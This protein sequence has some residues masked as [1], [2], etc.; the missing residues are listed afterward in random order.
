[1]PKLGVAAP[2]IAVAGS[3][4]NLAA[5]VLLLVAGIFTLRQSRRA[6]TLHWIYAWVKIPA[7]IV[8]AIAMAWMWHQLF[9]ASGAFARP[10]WVTLFPVIPALV[11]LIYPSAL[12]IVLRSRAVRAYYSGESD[13]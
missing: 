12:M 8:T 7:A 13:G 10:G 11:G 2:T 1:M 9:S 4:V 5:A 3:G 6:A